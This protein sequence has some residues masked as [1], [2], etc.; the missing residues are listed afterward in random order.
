M[1]EVVLKLV[2]VGQGTV[3]G[4]DREEHVLADGP[5]WAKTWGQEG[6]GHTD[7]AASS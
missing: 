4:E 3:G 2:A 7:E 1:E 5:A 6:V